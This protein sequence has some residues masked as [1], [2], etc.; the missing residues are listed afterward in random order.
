MQAWGCAVPLWPWLLS[1]PACPCTT[2]LPSVGGVGQ[3]FL[4]E[5]CPCG[6]EFLKFLLHTVVQCY[7]GVAP[8]HPGH[9]CALVM[10][11]A[12]SPRGHL[13]SQ[14]GALVLRLAFW[15]ALETSRSSVAE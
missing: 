7:G 14:L 11:T 15:A 4:R 12:E 9:S 8:P 2:E 6:L 10:G 3:G 1:S 5:E 13:K